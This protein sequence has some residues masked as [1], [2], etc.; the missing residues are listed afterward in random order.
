M[1]TNV[2]FVVVAIGLST[3]GCRWV[4]SQEETWAGD[5]G[6]GGKVDDDDNSGVGCTTTEPRL[7]PVEA[8]VGPLG[9]EQRI[10]ELIDSAQETLDLQMYC[11]T[12]D[13]LAIKV[14]EAKSRGVAMRVILD[15]GPL[16]CSSSERQRLIDAGVP[17]RDAAGFDHSHAKYLIVDGELVAIMSL[18]FTGVAMAT[19]RNYGVIDRD[20][21]DI[22]DALAIFDTDWAAAGG[23][24]PQP[25][26]LKCT[27]LV[28]V[29]DNA[30]TRILAFIGGA[31]STLD[32]EANYVTDTRVLNAIEAAAARGVNVRVILEKTTSSAQKTADYFQPL[33][34][35]VHY[36]SGFYLH[37]K[38]IIADGVAL[39]GS[40]NFSEPG[41]ENNRE[42][43]AMAF[44][45]EAA[46]VIARQFETDWTETPPAF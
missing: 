2:V 15:P 24:P 33:D 8:F 19:Q 20:P 7:V 10:G 28:V 1:R 32:V 5:E 3:A 21:E 43:G 11:F 14:I 9:V 34:I 13:A 35:P 31:R 25:A 37:A 40:A 17:V 27:R 44:E 12:V 18:N 30:L 23:E 16:S 42:L 29:P 36:S 46:S 22:A 45:P 26:D 4:G 6:P 39:V 38:L 41:L